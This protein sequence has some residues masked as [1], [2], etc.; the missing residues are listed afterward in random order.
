MSKL[1][2]LFLLAL[3]HSIEISLMLE[4]VLK[5]FSMPVLLMAGN[6]VHHLATCFGR[7]YPLPLSHTIAWHRQDCFHSAE[8]HIFFFFAVFFSFPWTSA[9]EFL[10]FW[11]MI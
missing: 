3:L 11:L 6:T 1:H 4:T 9:T 8:W 5:C 10:N 7:L 2:I